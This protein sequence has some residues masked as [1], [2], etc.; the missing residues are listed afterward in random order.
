MKGRFIFALDAV[1][2]P[3]TPAEKRD[4]SPDVLHKGSDQDLHV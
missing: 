4:A 1:H 2:P 3:N